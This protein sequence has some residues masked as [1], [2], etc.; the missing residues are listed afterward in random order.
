MEDA[1]S[2]R[3]GGIDTVLSDLG[4]RFSFHHE[5]PSHACQEIQ[6][7]GPENVCGLPVDGFGETVRAEQLAE[8]R[9]E[10]GLS[11]SGGQPGLDLGPGDRTRKGTKS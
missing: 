6:E 7:P 11:P 8:L 4:D 9:R 5:E 10:P 3:C 2:R 1:G